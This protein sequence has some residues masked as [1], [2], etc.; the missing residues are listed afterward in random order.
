M[1]STF[2]QV[3]TE[4]QRKNRA[5]ESS[6]EDE[7]CCL[8]CVEMEIDSEPMKILL[9]S[10]KDVLT[11]TAS[12]VVQGQTFAVTALLALIEVRGRHIVQ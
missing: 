1:M 10:A 12:L 3:D 8:D 6:D 2:S 7:C 11:K 5:E 9:P 4:R